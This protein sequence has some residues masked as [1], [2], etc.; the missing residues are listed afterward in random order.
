M[1]SLLPYTALWRLVVSKMIDHL[2]D[3]SDMD[4]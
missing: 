4:N 3:I 1:E 2:G